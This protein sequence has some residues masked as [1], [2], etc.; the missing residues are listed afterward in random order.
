LTLWIVCGKQDLPIDGNENGYFVYD[1][2]SHAM[3]KPEA[4]RWMIER[5]LQQE[6]KIVPDQPIWGRWYKIDYGPI[7][8]DDPDP[9]R[10]KE[11]DIKLRTCA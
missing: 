2:R 8:D 9:T 1:V 11:W 6:C 4:I 5:G 10:G 7:I 3:P